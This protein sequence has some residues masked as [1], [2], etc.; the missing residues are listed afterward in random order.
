MWA[1]YESFTE[2]AKWWEDEHL[3]WL[4]AE[5]SLLV[6]NMNIRFLRPMIQGV[7]D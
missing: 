7:D 1:E 5:L 6:D 4:M 2:I 3:Q